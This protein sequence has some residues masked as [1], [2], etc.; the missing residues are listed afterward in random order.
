M[1]YGHNECILAVHCKH[2]GHHHTGTGKRKLRVYDC[3]NIR[4]D[5]TYTDIHI[6]VRDE[7]ERSVSGSLTFWTS[8]TATS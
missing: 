2:L 1:L 3:H 7:W 8:L 5:D 6:G 4:S